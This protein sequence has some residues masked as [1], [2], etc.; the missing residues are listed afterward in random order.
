ML[1]REVL[2]A[3]GKRVGQELGAGST[4]G[5]EQLEEDIFACLIGDYDPMHNDPGWRFDHDWGGTVVLGFHVL[6]LLP[7]IMAEAGLGGETFVTLGLDR[8]RFASSLPVGA[9]AHWTVT[10]TAVEREADRTLLRTSHRVQ[11][12]GL[13]KPMM[14]AEHIGALYHDRPRYAPLPGA[15]QEPPVA[16]AEIPAGR[17]IPE[18]DEH[19]EDFYERVLG[20]RGSWLGATP[21]A[22]VDK[23]STDI[24]TMLTAGG[25]VLSDPAQARARSPFGEIVLDPFHL[26]ALRSYFMPQVG[27][28]VLSDVRM[29]AFN[30]GL[31][32]ARWHA[33]VP[34]DSRLRDHVLML[35]AREK[36]PG[37]YLVKARHVVEAEGNP[38]AV[39]TA[40]CLTLFAL[41]D[42]ARSG[43]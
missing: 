24:F 4:I 23:R 12:P 1:A 28:P 34:A 33:P 43:R 20:R 22:T 7:R 9:R 31:D 36:A 6:S 30:Y 15:P 41:L 10:L 40:D 11:V 17:R 18:A 16:I 2:D 32:Q 19:G 42:A 14:V 21:W 29:A 13:E 37:R 39:L 27:L 8:V 3:L 5:V 26:L 35:E 25:P 38:Q